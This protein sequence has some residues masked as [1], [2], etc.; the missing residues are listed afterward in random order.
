MARVIVAVWSAVVIGLMYASILVSELIAP[1]NL[2]SRHTDF[3]YAPPQSVHLFHE[4]RFVGPFVYALQ[5]RLNM[6]NLKREYTD[7]T[8]GPLESSSQDDPELR[9]AMMAIGESDRMTLLFSKVP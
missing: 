8:T 9:K 3:I 2:H 7:D 5:Y 6:E 1:Y 4:G